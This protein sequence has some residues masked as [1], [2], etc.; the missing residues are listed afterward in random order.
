MGSN[1]SLLRWYS[2]FLPQASFYK[3]PFKPHLARDNKQLA[4]EPFDSQHSMNLVT[5]HLCFSNRCMFMLP[6]VARKLKSS[7]WF[8]SEQVPRWWFKPNIVQ[9]CGHKNLTSFFRLYCMSK[10]RMSFLKIVN[11]RIYIKLSWHQR[12]WKHLSFK[13][14][15]ACIKTDLIWFKLSI[16]INLVHIHIE[17]FSLWSFSFSMSE[18]TL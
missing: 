7:R 15:Q 2:P 6:S 9:K 11:S 14:F 17:Y 4:E 18:T 16:R 5:Q 8:W 3:R 12:S 10:D 13:A 1:D